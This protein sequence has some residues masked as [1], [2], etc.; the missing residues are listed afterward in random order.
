M[1]IAV[2]E[3][4]RR[5]YLEMAGEDPARVVTVP[6]GS[7]DPGPPAAARR[8]EVR[9]ELGV[10]TDVVVA[11]MVAVMRPG[12]GHDVLLEA[13]P[14][15]VPEV[16]IVLAGDGELMTQVASG[17]RRHPGRVVLAGFIEDVPRL[18]AGVDLVV[19]PS[20]ADAFPTAL[21]H[22]AAAGLPVVASAVGGVPEIVTPASGILVDPGGTIALAGAINRL[23]ADPLLRA[24]MGAAAR[25]RFEAN[26]TASRWVGALRGIYEGVLAR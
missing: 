7:P 5:W 10:G 9:T 25:E 15:L 16:T 18:L 12:K 17:A 8:Q 11:A 20:R 21:V 6:N 1:T 19:H 26:F 4:Q 2:S 14:R 3:A 24:R 13:V 23:A 22:A